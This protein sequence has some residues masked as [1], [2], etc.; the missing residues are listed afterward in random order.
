MAF[1][2]RETL[3]IS[4]AKHKGNLVLLFKQAGQFWVLQTKPVIVFLNGLGS[5]LRPLVFLSVICWPT[6]FTELMRSTV[7]WFAMGE[8]FM[9]L[10]GHITTTLRR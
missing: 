2:R 9:G 1:S 4:F 3:E 8:T 5:G 6:M 10:V 7:C